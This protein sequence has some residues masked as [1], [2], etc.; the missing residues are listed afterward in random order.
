MHAKHFVKTNQPHAHLRARL[1]FFVFASDLRFVDKVNQ[2][3]LKQHKML[4]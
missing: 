3:S 2:S 4:S 1:R